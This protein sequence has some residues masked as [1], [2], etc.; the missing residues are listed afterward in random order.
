VDRPV[1]GEDGFEAGEL[2]LRG[3]DGPGCGELVVVFVVRDRL[4]AG[5]EEVFFLVGAGVCGVGGIADR[6][7]EVGGDLVVVEVRGGCPDAVEE[8]RVGDTVVGQRN[9]TSSATISAFSWV[10]PPFS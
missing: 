4:G 7:V 5:L 9:S 2:M 8:V 6:V 10:S 3:D 1:V